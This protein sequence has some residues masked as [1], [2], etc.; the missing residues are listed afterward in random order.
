MLE[1]KNGKFFPRK[2]FSPLLSLA[3]DKK[4]SLI[5]GAR[6]TGKT[7]L[8]KQLYLEFSKANK[9]LFLDLDVLS[10]YEKV[11]TFEKLLNT[12]KV[13][14]YAEDQ[15]DFFFLFLDEFQK[16]PSMTK[17]MKNVYDNLDNVK[18]YASGS[19]S[20]TIKD[21]VQESLAGRKRIIELFPLDFEEFL[22]FKQRHKLAKNLLN[23]SKL[24]GRDLHSSLKEYYALLEEFLIFGGYPEVALKSTKEEKIEVLSSIFDLY[25]KKDLVEYLNMEKILETKKL[26]EFL[27]VNNGQKIKY[28]ALSAITSLTFNEIKR[29]IEILSE[30]YVIEV[31]RPFY[32]NKNKEIVK[33]PKIYF[34]DP[35]VRNF[36]INNFNGLALRN[37]YG[38][39][40]EGFVISELLKKGTRNLKF[41]QDKNGNEVDIIIEGTGLIPIEVKFKQ[42]LKSEDFRGI[43]AF[44]KEYTKVKKSYLIN[45]NFQ[46]TQRKIKFILPYCLNLR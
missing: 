27:A 34:V 14:E 28:E 40:F 36:F 38:F 7:T 22:W 24:K 2:L 19:S 23:I 26:I 20:V 37:D 9:C 25:V 17:I 10:N 12:I 35:G 45:L 44:L 29:Q 4:V 43:E 5:L 31:L 1:N 11:S 21:Q 39:L 46:K 3:R 18:I 30:T 6:Q 16:Y 41:W 33:I 42:N 32:T 13:N 8:L 15:K